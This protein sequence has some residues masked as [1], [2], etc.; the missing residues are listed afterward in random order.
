MAVSTTWANLFNNAWSTSCVTS[1][2]FN[3]ALRLKLNLLALS[4]LI[5]SLF[6]IFICPVS[7][8]VSVPGLPI[9]AQYLTASDP[10]SSNKSIGVTTFPFDLLIFFRSGS[11]IQPLILAFFQGNEF[12]SKWLLTT[13]ENNQVLMI[14]WDWG[15]KSIGKIRLK[16]SLSNSQEPAICGVSEEVAQ[17]SITSGSPINPFG[18]FLCDSSNP[19]GASLWGSIGNWF[20][21]GTIIWP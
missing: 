16:R 9:A 19:I 12:S 21:S 4:N 1:A 6:P 14:S 8:A 15:R 3:V 20:S 7:K 18:L 10:Y 11:R 2:L 17:V 13:V 5:A